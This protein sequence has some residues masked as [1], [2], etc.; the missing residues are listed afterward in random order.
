MYIIGI[1]ATFLALYYGRTRIQ[2]MPLK[3]RNFWHC[4]ILRLTYKKVHTFKPEF[5]YWDTVIMVRKLL[6][7]LSSLFFTGYKAFE[8]VLL[9]IIFL[10][11]LLLQNNKPYLVTSLNRL[12]QVTLL[13]SMLV[14]IAGL[15]AYVGEFNPA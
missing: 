4:F 10:L 11:S 3:S 6:T 12:E 2:S 9:I 5:E 13:A 8:A 1:P 14:L 15:L 7:V